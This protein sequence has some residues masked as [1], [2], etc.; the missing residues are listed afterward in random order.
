M[1]RLVQ[2]GVELGQFRNVD[3]V[4]AARAMMGP[5]MVE[6]IWTHALRGESELG[7]GQAWID[8]QV[9]ILLRGIGAFSGEVESGSPSEN[10]SNQG[11]GVEGGG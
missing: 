10:A 9:D 5:I 6:I 7:R 4:A 2:R 3:P 1:A 11:S 8:A